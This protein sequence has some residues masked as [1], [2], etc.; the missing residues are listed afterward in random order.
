MIAVLLQKL[1]VFSYRIQVYC[2][3]MVYFDESAS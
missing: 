2:A 3:S 1:M